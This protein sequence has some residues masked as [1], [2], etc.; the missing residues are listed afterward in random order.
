[1]SAL[2]LALWLAGIAL[3]AVGYARARGPWARLRALEATAENLRRYDSWRGGPRPPDEPVGVTGADVMRGELRRQVQLWLAVAAL[4]VV[5][6]F[7]GFA[8]R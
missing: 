5:A 1:M 3:I 7:A 2:N 8:L 4:G 6:V